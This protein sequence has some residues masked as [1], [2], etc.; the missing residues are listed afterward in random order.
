MHQAWD[1][2]P[3]LEEHSSHQ[4]AR[5]S[6]KLAH[7]DGAPTG[8]GAPKREKEEERAQGTAS[9]MVCLAPAQGWR[10]RV[11]RKPLIDPGKGCGKYV[12]STATP[13]FMTGSMMHVREFV[14][15]D[16]VPH[17]ASWAADYAPSLPCAMIR[18]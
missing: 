15:C 10:K 6:Q 3:S 16:H 2:Q 11:L 9:S 12:V 18:P 14:P 8:P 17:P 1:N 5:D 7:A 13:V 4:G